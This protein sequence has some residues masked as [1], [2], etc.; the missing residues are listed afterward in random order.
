MRHF[1]SAKIALAILAAT[2]FTSCDDDQELSTRPSTDPGKEY[3]FVRVLIADEQAA[4]LTQLTPATAAIESFNAKFPL[5]TLYPTASGR[6]AAVMYANQNLVEMFDTGL[7]SH[8]DHIDVKGTPKWGA[9]SS[10]GARPS[11]FKSKGTESLIFNDGD[12]TLSVGNDV[13][14]HVAGAKFKAINVGLLP[15]HGAMAQFDNGNYAVTMAKASGAS[16]TSVKIINKAG[17]EVQA[18]KLETG[19]IHG[20]ATDGSNAVFGCWTTTA[21][22]SGSVLVVKASGEQRLILNPADFGA[23]RLGT[24][25]YAKGAKKYIGYVATKGAYLIDITTDK[26]TPI[27]AGADAFQCKPDYAG[28]NLHV[29]TLDGKLRVY[30]LAT[31]ALKRENSV[32]PATPAADAYKPMLEA[33]EKFAYIAVPSLGEVHQIKVS[34]LSTAAKHKVTSRPVRLTVLGHESDQGH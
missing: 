17:A 26:I 12:G 14:F 31:G 10:T 3:R 28:N 4:T 15:H 1:L 19:N 2:V 6:F 13:E 34:D 22:T 23:F 25:Y 5:A 24:I 30:D 11:H 9:I 7:E 27:Y 29:L 16:P 32:I 20:N 18:A 8:D 33:T 21:N